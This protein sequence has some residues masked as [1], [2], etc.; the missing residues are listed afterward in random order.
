MSPVVELRLERWALIERAETITH[1]AV[2]ETRAMSRE[3]LAEVESL[4][5]DAEEFVGKIRA[6]EAEQDRQRNAPAA[7][8]RAQGEPFAY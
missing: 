1:K 7:G 4:L 8:Y 2:S 5:G 6:A 3:E